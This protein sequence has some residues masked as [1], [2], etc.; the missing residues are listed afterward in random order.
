M[1]LSDSG[2][3]NTADDID[4]IL[5]NWRQGDCVKGERCW[6]LFRINPDLPLTDAAKEAVS[7]ENSSEAAEA[8]VRGFMIATQSCD[9]V[10]SHRDR[11]F[12]EVCPLVDVNEGQ[13]EEIR[14]NLRVNYAYIPGV[15]KDLLVADLDQI[16]TV[17]KAVL[18]TWERIEGC[19]DEAESRSLSN[20]LARKRSRFAFPD[21]F[22]E[23]IKKLKDRLK[24]KHSKNSAEGV[25]LRSLREVRVKA[26]PSWK[27]DNIDITFYFI[28]GEDSLM[29][30]EGELW[31]Q[32][33]EGWLSLV[34]P[35][36]RF[37]KFYGMVQTI[38][39]LTAREYLES[40]SMDLDHLSVS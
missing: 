5:Q 29:L 6:I 4:G 9:I 39:D 23:S 24:G 34:P 14:R 21:D 32:Y 15:A 31:V 22:I 7:C 36:G 19:S 13:L 40:D 38:D 1:K 30:K 37:K 17:E 33:L 28:K 20:S 35:S 26:E 3:E 2:G 11:P 25:F 27:A 16:M 12:I 8:K 10:R 18:L